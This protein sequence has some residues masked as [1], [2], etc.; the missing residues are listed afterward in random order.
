VSEHV[1]AW[2]VVNNS[3][4]R[5]IFCSITKCPRSFLVEGDR[6]FDQALADA[7]AHRK[8]VDE[9]LERWRQERLQQV[10]HRSYTNRLQELERRGGNVA[11]LRELL[12][13]ITMAVN[14]LAQRVANVE[15]AYMRADHFILHLQGCG[16]G[17]ETL[18]YAVGRAAAVDEL[19][20]RVDELEHR[21][22]P[23]EAPR[24]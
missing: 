19:R 15:A 24:G 1:H 6:G 3:D 9:S 10:R 13:E 14:G 21:I 20:T 23:K 12:Q 18:Q 16:I 17:V 2:Y 5:E 7:K 11:E 8:Q 4:E 22:A